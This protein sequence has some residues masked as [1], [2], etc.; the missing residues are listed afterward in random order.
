MARDPDQRP[1]AV[2]AAT[3]VRER[4][5]R[6]RLTAAY[7]GEAAA[8]LADR[9]NPAARSEFAP[10]YRGA[11]RLVVLPQLGV[12]SWRASRSSVHPLLG[13]EQSLATYAS[14]TR[15]RRRRGRRILLGY[16]RRVL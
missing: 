13:P 1:A 7:C 11:A 14:R 9:S 6:K 4:T 5:V 3:G 12:R 16:S 8:G 15:G 2:A 10:P